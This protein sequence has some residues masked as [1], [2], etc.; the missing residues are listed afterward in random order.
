MYIAQ[1]QFV[2]DF[3]DI[4]DNDLANMFVFCDLKLSFIPHR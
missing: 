3:M 2:T 4:T 1:L